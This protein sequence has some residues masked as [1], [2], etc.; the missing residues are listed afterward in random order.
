MMKLWV[1]KAVAALLMFAVVLSCTGYETVLAASEDDGIVLETAPD[2][3]DDALTAGDEMVGPALSGDDEA[4]EDKAADAA[5]EGEEEGLTSDGADGDTGKGLKIKE[6]K[7]LP[8][9]ER[10]IAVPQKGTEEEAVAVLPE[11]WKVTLGDGTEKDVK[12]SWKCIDDFDDKDYTSFVFKGEIADKT[13]SIAEDEEILNDLVMELYFE[14][15]GIEKDGLLISVLSPNTIMTGLDKEQGKDASSEAFLNAYGSGADA[16][17]NTDISYAASKSVLS[18]SAYKIMKGISPTPDNYLYNKLTVEEK[19]FYNNIDAVMTDFLYYGKECTKGVGGRPM[20]PYISAGSMKLD[21]MVDVLNIYLYD[22]PQAFFF[23]T[24]PL[25]DPDVDSKQGSSVA[26]TIYPDTDTPAKL[27]AR[28][29]QIASNI[30]TVSKKV[31]K[32]NNEYNR[33]RLAQ[34]LICKRLTF[35]GTYRV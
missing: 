6:I 2:V 9:S 8:V 30:Q 10:I 23:S 35:P 4:D 21:Q 24:R 19:R 5:A 3:E 33:M 13:V 14:D 22:N 11:T 29:E 17:I 1:R 18:A 12:V 7:K 31:N 27:K 15:A 32:K 25:I 20:T 26:I 16:V 34:S 28:A